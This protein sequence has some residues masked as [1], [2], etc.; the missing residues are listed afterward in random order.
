[1]ILFPVL[2]NITLLVTLSVVYVL[3]GRYLDQSSKRVQILS[4]LVF[5]SF[6]ILGIYNSVELEPGLIFDG[7][8]IILSVA[9][10]FGGPIV[11]VI[12]GVMALAYRIW[13]GGAGVLMGSLV[14]FESVF[15]GIFFYYFIQKRPKIPA[16]LL[17]F[18]M[19]F[20]V[21]VL[22]V[23]L[24][25]TLPEGFRLQTFANVFIP[26]LVL[27]PIASFLVCVL[28]HSQGRYLN[29]VKELS[30][31][32]ARFK[33]L[34]DENHMVFLVIDPDTVQIKN[35]NKAAAS[36]YGYSVDEL[37]SMKIS[38]INTLER[39]EIA[40]RMS[41]AFEN[42]QNRFLMQHK[43][44]SGEIRD[45]EVFAGPVDYDGKTHLYS[46]VS[47]VTERL[48]IENK[49]KQSELSYREL[50]NAV[51]DAIYI[52]DKN[53]V[54]LDINTGAEAMYGY[55]KEFLIGKDPSV[56]SAPGKNDPDLLTR[57]FELLEKGEE[58][59]FEFWGKRKN[60]QVFPKYVRIY[61]TK[62][63]GNDA[64][65]AIGHDI[66]HRKAAQRELEESRFN[67]NVL[68]N[69]SDDIILL[70]DVNG[71]ILTYNKAFSS[72]YG[73]EKNYK[74]ENLFAVLPGSE[75]FEMEKYFKNVIE[76]SKP[77]SF[78]GFAN[79]KNW[80]ITFYPI[81]NQKAT[82]ER[83]AMYSQDITLQRR[84]FNLQQNLQVAEKS[85][86]LKQQ[87]LSNM[88]HEMRTPMNGIIGMA[89]LMA[90]TPLSDIQKDYLTTIKESS[91]TL[92]AL[93]NDILDLAKFES[94]KMP[95]HL[96]HVSLK[97]LEAKINQLF[98]QSAITKGV[99]FD[100]DITSELPANIVSDEKR[101][102][103][104]LT[105]IIGNALKFTSKGFVKVKAELVSKKNVTPHTLKFTVED[106]GIGIDNDFQKQIFDEFAQLDNS[107][108]RKYEGSGLGLAISK[109]IVELLDGKI[110]VDSVK[111]KGSKFWFTI[112]T[113]QAADVGQIKEEPGP[114]LFESLGLQVLMVEDK[115][116]NR[117]VASLILKNMGC[118]VDTAENGLIGVDRMMKNNYDVVLMDIQMPVMDG[119][120]AV[121]A[122]RKSSRKQPVIIGLSA[123]AMHG[124]AEKYIG[125]GMDDYIT[126]PI[127]PSVLYEK[128]SA[129]KKREG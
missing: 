55:P 13:I 109:R 65:I 93:I 84:M 126:K 40:F 101:L 37:K 35:A 68:I 8:S 54:F 38:Q 119:I 94:G 1:M 41:L 110:G 46:I 52:Q 47:D 16:F 100:I 59:G 83:V 99:D 114:L 29:L 5:G 67:L 44:A 123:E 28:F 111:G 88:S 77:I 50:F 76:T 118:H 113:G 122:I 21:H 97:N 18:I 26:V 3:V 39:S 9:G 74:G 121:Q 30:E 96:S 19:G 89:E 120:T 105:N 82:V 124:D 12:A 115:I 62:Y 81:L 66:T 32:E 10:L 60:G 57:N 75:A 51:K 108:T 92:L 17:Y 69:V 79:E 25:I 95:L 58:V 86:Q 112:K 34:F 15:L 106:S 11:G 98:K 90:S 45:V 43:L 24:I 116:I 117:K 80:W 102:M 4:G 103:Q 128:L 22:M 125:M 27:Y 42:M 49:L 23:V 6:V 14:I 33:Q 56:L 73:S 53:G 48:K 7:R 71:N 91:S 107:R 127:V 2:N 87:F 104:V 85:A 78:E 129:I 20:L 61:K 70:L 31:S 72:S 64:Y 63:F 36:Y